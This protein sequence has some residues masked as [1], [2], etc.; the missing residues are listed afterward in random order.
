MRELGTWAARQKLAPELVLCSTFRPDAADPGAAVAEPRRPPQVM[1]EGGL[2]LADPGDLLVRLRRVPARCGSVLV[3][4]HNPGLHEF[5]VLLTRS[6]SGPLGRRLS[7]GMPTG[8]LA[9]FALDGPWSALDHGAARLTHY[10]TPKEL[11][12]A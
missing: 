9:G 11:R 5:A 3:V 8:A 1:I 6:A 2:Y 4:G 7:A 12:D 10:V